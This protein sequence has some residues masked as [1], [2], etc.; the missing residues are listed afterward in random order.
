[1]LK[2][3]IKLCS[4]ASSECLG[5]IMPLKG[6]CRSHYK[7]KWR[8]KH[9]VR[10]KAR[11]KVLR[12]ANPDRWKKQCKKYKYSTNGRYHYMLKD[13]PRRNLECNLLYEEYAALITQPCYYCEEPL[14]ASCCTGLDRIDNKLGYIRGN[15]LPCCGDC[16]IIRT[17]K[18]TVEE[19]KVAMMA[20][21]QFRLGK[22][23]ATKT[24]TE[25]NFNK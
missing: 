8:V 9:S 3:P 18:Y 25:S 16:N 15:V 13:A 19:T 24:N 20:I 7:K 5:P 11:E 1:M 2:N 6:L 4:Q 14:P 12:A 22:Y 17:D 21:K 10:T 23:E